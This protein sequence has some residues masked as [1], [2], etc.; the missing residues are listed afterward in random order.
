[1]TTFRTRKRDNP[2]VQIDKTCLEDSR[3]SWKARGILVYLLSKPDGWQVRIVDLINK[4]P[5]GI[6]AVKSAIKELEAVGYMKRTRIHRDGRLDWET[7][8]YETPQAK[9]VQSV[10]S[11]SIE[12]QSIENLSIEN[13][14]VESQ[15]IETKPHSNN[16]SSNN[17][18]SNNEFTNAIAS[19]AKT[20]RQAKCQTSCS[21]SGIVQMEARFRRKGKQYPWKTGNGI[22]DFDKG[23]VDYLVL[24]LQGMGGSKTLGDAIAYLQN[25]QSPRNNLDPD[26]DGIGE[27]LGK[28][29]AHWKEYQKSLEMRRQSH[30]PTQHTLS[31]SDI[32][33]L[34]QQQ[35]R[36]N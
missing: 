22:N 29:L 36:R 15:S 13:L 34:R 24:W 9:E 11:Q 28:I 31:A 27:G 19:N 35:I 5:E 25:H 17:E 33:A 8:V 20:L 10:E 18:S 23:F 7:E 14:S 30:Q 4:S 12:G 21:N 32:D 3:L 2:F 1:M 16:E 26:P 6:T